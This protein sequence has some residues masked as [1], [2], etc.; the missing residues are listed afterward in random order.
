MPALAVPACAPLFCAPALSCHPPPPPFTRPLLQASTTVTSVQLQTGETVEGAFIFLGESGSNNGMDNPVCA[1]VSCLG[2]GDAWVLW[3]PGYG[4][5]SVLGLL[6]LQ[7][8]APRCDSPNPCPGPP[9]PP[10]T[11]LPSLRPRRRTST[12]PPTPP[13]L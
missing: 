2:W 11:A 6:L 7:H 8:S 9:T 3:V 13:A 4:C 12:C 10:G 1:M 5:A